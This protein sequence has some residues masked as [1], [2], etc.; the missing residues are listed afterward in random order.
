MKKKIL[1]INGHLNAGGVE[2]SLVDILK[3]I[4]YQK[5]DVDLL[6]LEEYGDYYSEIPSNV[7]VRLLCLKNTY[8]SLFHSLF[9]CLKSKDWV[10]LKMRIVFLAMKFLGQDKIA[11]A[12]KTLT[13]NTI[14]DCAIGFRPGIC[15]QIV[16]FAINA[17][18]KIAWW[19]HGEVNIDRKSYLNVVIH[20]DK[21]A[22]VSQSCC[23]ML[24]TEFPSLIGKFIVIPNMIDI[25]TL[26]EKAREYCPFEKNSIFHIVSICRLSS[27][28]H[29]EN[30]LFV[31]QQLK[32]RNYSFCWHLI[33][34]GELKD[35]LL[36]I[37]A[38]LNISD[39]FIFEGAQQNPYPYL[40]A[41][42][43][44]VHPSYVESQGIVVLEAMALGVPCVVTRSTGP[45]EYILDETNGLLAE[46]SQ[47]SLA[48][49]AIR[50][51]ENTSL[52]QRIKSLTNCPEHFQPENI[53][54][55][56]EKLWSE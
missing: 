43:L 33:G 19:H 11:W 28:K 53:M 36:K 6:L 45:C 21:I 50:L 2:R 25:D 26:E 15:T 5:Y 13:N 27:E 29:V 7:S 51:L 9:H 40:K 23:K 14:Y 38:E 52:Y 10:C 54:S 49:Q 35:N 31:A 24:M 4:D 16:A 3:H 47:D 32:I 41:A 56:I 22:V 17:S 39:V 48:A 44:F 12:K 30:I 20:C 34:S 55:I 42:D 8:G 18:K 37:A 1:F 46:Q